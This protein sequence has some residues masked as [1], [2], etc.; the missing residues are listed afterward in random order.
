MCPISRSATVENQTISPVERCNAELSNRNGAARAQYLKSGG[1][2][3]A[4]DG[5]GL[6]ARA[7]WSL[8][9]GG[10]G[11]KE[12]YYRDFTDSA[13]ANAVIE[14]RALDRPK[15]RTETTTT[16]APKK[17][18]KKMEPTIK[19]VALKLE[20]F[21]NA[22]VGG[23]QCP[24]RVRLY[25]FVE[26]RRAFAGQLIF[27]GPYFLTPITKLDFK[28]AGTRTVTAEYPV[29]W[30]D[31]GAKT[32]GPGLKKQS[33][34]LRVNVADAAGKVLESAHE[35]VG[36]VCRPTRV[37]PGGGAAEDDLSAGTANN[38]AGQAT[39]KRTH[40]PFRAQ[41]NPDAATS[42]VEA[43]FDV[44]IRRADRQGQDG[45]PQV[46][47]YNSGPERASGCSLSARSAGSVRWVPVTSTS[48][49]AGDTVKYDG[50][51]P[52]AVNL[53]LRVACPEEPE[54]RQANNSYRLP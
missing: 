26:T 4:K 37:S 16:G 42:S 52:S 32:S 6:A 22:T 50:A 23:Q 25:G 2:V 5:Y 38:A 11:F 48:I 54:D 31:T 15:A 13:R 8:R 24:T 45:R 36:L 35:T 18:G 19:T 10:V 17:P 14:C 7:K 9:P 39:G 40:K 34:A 30:G 20:P 27:M 46:W 1:T 33:L 44:R 3:Q 49:A 43:D 29:K 28:T 51:M 47:L 12:P 41:A 21:A 53:E